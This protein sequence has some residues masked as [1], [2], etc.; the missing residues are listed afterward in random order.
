MEFCRIGLICIALLAVASCGGG[1]GGGGDQSSQ[2]QAGSGYERIDYSGSAEF[3]EINAGNAMSFMVLAYDSLD[4]F[5]D[6]VFYDEYNPPDFPRSANNDI[7]DYDG[8]E[9]ESGSVDVVENTSETSD[10]IATIEIRDCLIDGVVASGF[11]RYS[12]D[13]TRSLNDQYAVIT[14]VVRLELSSA[15]LSVVLSGTVSSLFEGF[16]GDLTIYIESEDRSYEIRNVTGNSA[17]MSGVLLVDGEGYVDVVYDNQRLTL[18]GNNDSSSVAEFVKN[19]R[20]VFES[21][22]VALYPDVS[23]SSFELSVEEFYD[24]RYLSSYFSVSQNSFNVDRLDVVEVVYRD[25]FSEIKNFLDVS[26]VVTSENYACDPEWTSSNTG[27]TFAAPCVEEFSIS[28]SVRTNDDVLDISIGINVESLQAEVDPIPEQYLVGGELLNIALSI[29]NAVDDGPFGYEISHAPEGI[30]VN[31]DGVIYGNPKLMLPSSGASRFSVEVAVKNS[32]QVLVGFDVRLE[33]QPYQA[34]TLVG[35]GRFM[36]V[37]E[38]GWSSVDGGSKLASLTIGDGQAYIATIQNGRN[39]IAPLDSGQLAMEL[40]IGAWWKDVD[41]NGTDELVL[42][43]DNELVVFSVNTGQVVSRFALSISDG[44]AAEYLTAFQYFET[45]HLVFKDSNRVNTYYVLN[46]LTGVSSTIEYA[47]DFVALGEFTQDG[48]AELLFSDGAVLGLSGEELLRVSALSEDED[49]FVGDIFGNSKRYLVRGRFGYRQVVGAEFEFSVQDLGAFSEPE[50]ITVNLSAPDDLSWYAYFQF[51]NL[52]EDPG[53]ELVVNDPLMRFGNLNVFLFRNGI[54]EVATLIDLKQIATTRTSVANITGETGV[55]GLV[56]RAD[57]KDF[58]VDFPTGSYE[59][60]ITEVAEFS[61]NG[62]SRLFKEADGYSLFLDKERL[63]FNNLGQVRSMERYAVSNV[64]V[65][66]LESLSQESNGQYLWVDSYY[67]DYWRMAEEGR[68]IYERESYVS[69]RDL[70]SGENLSTIEEDFS[71]RPVIGNY[72]ANIEPDFFSVDRCINF[73]PDLGLSKQLVDCIDL[74]D[75]ASDFVYRNK[76]L[77]ADLDGDGAVDFVTLGVGLY[78][79][80]SISAYEATESSTELAFEYRGDEMYPTET[81]GLLASMQD[82]DGDDEQELVVAR[83]IGD[84]T[85]IYIFDGYG[86]TRNFK[87]PMRAIKLP[88]F[89]EAESRRSIALVAQQYGVTQLYELSPTSGDVIWQSDPIEG[90]SY[91]VNFFRLNTGPDAFVSVLSTEGKVTI[92][93]GP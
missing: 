48:S 89:V 25:V 13:K 61:T 29:N 34:E 62:A 41:G 88:E 90:D 70:L 11:I 83:P 49:A 56:L 73:Y 36:S 31:S 20:G 12:V 44:G 51:M 24:W 9:C 85:N 76:E 6:L 77:L 80:L 71:G 2:H 16:W 92:Y 75:N 27:F 32:K 59:A 14:D 84:S 39:S 55:G 47:E 4:L 78:G 30:H 43:F 60:L 3:S 23:I 37:R 18:N 91:F 64:S 65:S 17:L 42:G 52:D 68:L 22:N 72:N 38:F 33:Q 81:Y 86:L 53:L 66:L 21:V 40:V 57:N 46:V 1:G 45:P 82:I 67:I 54:A 93:S 50:V 69:V 15:E 8:E 10:E 28:T 5:L 26:S 7:E 63:R 74:S 58:L 19:S 79:Y 35:N 87:V